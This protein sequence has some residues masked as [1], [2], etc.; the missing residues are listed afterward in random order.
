[1]VR[2]YAV[3]LAHGRA[4]AFE[5]PALQSQ[6][7]AEALRFALTR[8]GS[9][10]AADVDPYY[11]SF[12][13]VW[14]PDVQGPLPEYA[15]STGVRVGLAG[16][17]PRIVERAPG[18]QPGGFGAIS[19]AADALLPDWALEVVLRP[20]LPDVF[21]YLEDDDFRAKADARLVT[22]CLEH[23]AA[24]LVGFSMGSIVGYEV[25]RK[26]D[27]AF[28][29][30]A[31]ITAGSPIGLGPIN[32]PLRRLAGAERTPYPPGIRLWLNVWN[33]DDVATG[34]HG[35]A[36]SDLFPDGGGGGRE[37]Q[38]AE[39]A[40]RGATPM[41]PFGAHDALDYLSSL[42]MGTAL[43]AALLDVESGLD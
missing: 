6:Q 39:N 35:Q 1:M 24:V 9:R 36:L 37:I 12:G 40:G 19:R 8:V 31:F 33:D 28:P 34:V 26:A 38:N 27:A 30:R 7:W 29:V 17:P 3:V 2:R 42:A 4:A 23:D 15:T 10:F 18:P 5:I 22:T 14:R 41:N 43:H 21:Q 32:R 20:A 16:D 11:A 13:D 25:L